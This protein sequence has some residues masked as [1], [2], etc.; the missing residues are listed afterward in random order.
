MD[1]SSSSAIHVGHI[2]QEKDVL[3]ILACSPR[4]GGNSDTIAQQVAQGAR[5]SGAKAQVLYLRDFTITPCIGCNACFAHAQSQCVFEKKDDVEQL[6][7]LFERASSLCMVAPIYFYH[8]PAQL[9]ALLD[10]GQKYWAKRHKEEQS[11]G[12]QAK[13]KVGSWQKNVTVS[14][15][16]ARLRGENLF[17]GALLSLDLFWDVLQRNVQEK[18]VW[19]GYDGA[20]DFAHDAEACKTMQMVGSKLVSDS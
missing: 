13:Q 7:S 6:F 2:S 19:K 10:R 11:L 15:V 18:H 5:M 1:D 9:K 20:L 14:L 16:A 3:Y 12:Y 17:T 4:S 8:V